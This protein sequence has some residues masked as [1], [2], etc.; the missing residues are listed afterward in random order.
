[1]ARRSKD[2][3]GNTYQP[4]KIKRIRKF[5]FLARIRSK[6]GSLVIKRRRKKGRKVLTRSSEFGSKVEKNKKFSRRK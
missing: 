1:M 3:H 6:C 4:S 2:S 5:G